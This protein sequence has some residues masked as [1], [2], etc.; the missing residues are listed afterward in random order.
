MNGVVDVHATE[1]GRRAGGGLQERRPRR[2]R[3][4]GALR[5]RLRHRSGS[6][7]PSPRCAPAPRGSTWRTASSSARTSG[8]GRVRRRRGRRARGHS[9]S[10]WPAESWRLASSPPTRRTASSAP[11]APAG[12]SL[13]S[14]GPEH[15]LAE[16]A[17]PAENAAFR[18][19]RGLSCDSS[20]MRT[21]GESRADASLLHRAAGSDQSRSRRA[22][23]ARRAGSSSARWSARGSTRSPTTSSPCTTPRP[24]RSSTTTICRCSPPGTPRWRSGTRSPTRSSSS[25]R[26]GTSGAHQREALRIAAGFKGDDAF[27]AGVSEE[28]ALDTV[29]PWLS[30]ERLL[31]LAAGSG[32]SVLLGPVG[33]RQLG[34]LL[35]RGRSASSSPAAAARTTDLASSSFPG[36]GPSA[37]TG[38]LEAVTDGDTIRLAGLG[39]V[40]LIG[41]D[42]PEVYGHVE[43]FGREASAFVSRARPGR[44]D[45]ALPAGRGEA[46]PLRPRA[47]LRL[48]AGRPL[49][50]RAAG[51]SAATHSRSRSRPTWTSRTRFRA[52]AR[53]AREAGRGLWARPG[54]ATSGG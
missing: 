8:R 23:A 40:R 5:P 16:P 43:C 7:T 44:L 30:I 21:E 6:C 27:E 3:P 12:P 31:Q 42:T 48:A 33:L 29:L 20:S 41:V 54:C 18:Q 24:S 47:R 36:P 39:R 35:A 51:A 46:R 15:T 50:E 28:Q 22:S 26:S 45:R 49:P 25:E 14:W 13:C 53:R 19:G 1:P 38:T 37:R 17:P 52:A 2:P 9:C 34:R 32:R 11:T 10:R 4:R